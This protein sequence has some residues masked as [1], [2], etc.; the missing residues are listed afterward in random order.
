MDSDARSERSPLTILI[1]FGIVLITAV[2]LIDRVALSMAQHG[3]PRAIHAPALVHL[4][5]Q[6]VRARAAIEPFCPCFSSSRSGSACS[7]TKD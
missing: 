3:A 5:T 2:A 1:G 7:S 6:Y 4:L